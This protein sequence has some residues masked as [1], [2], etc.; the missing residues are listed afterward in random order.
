MK[1]KQLKDVNCCHK[2]YFPVTL[3]D[4]LDLC[5]ENFIIQQAICLSLLQCPNTAGYFHPSC[6]TEILSQTRLYFTICLISLTLSF[7]LMSCHFDQVRGGCDRQTFY[8]ISNTI[9]I[10]AIMYNSCIALQD[11]LGCC[12]IILL[13]TAAVLTK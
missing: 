13:K 2:N 1:I 4:D 8:T 6:E 5:Q 3:E 7:F 10:S 11:C 12:I 9:S